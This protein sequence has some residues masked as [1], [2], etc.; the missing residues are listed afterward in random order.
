MSEFS[1]YLNGPDAL[2][3]E[4]L[5]QF[6]DSFLL[7]EKVLELNRLL[8]SHKQEIVG[9]KETIDAM[10]KAGAYAEN[11]EIGSLLGILEE[12]YPHYRVTKQRREIFNLHRVIK[13]LKDELREARGE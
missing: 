7:K 3:A 1:V 6:S 8:A 11:E 9:L 2:K 12:E 10:R 13:G 4:V 5:R